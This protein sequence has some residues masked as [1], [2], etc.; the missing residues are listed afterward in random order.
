MAKRIRE[1]V[2]R[3][4]REHLEVMKGDFRDDDEIE[5]RILCGKS[6][7]EHAV[8]SFYHSDNVW[9]GLHQGKPVL[10]FGH[11]RDNFSTSI[12]CPWFASTNELLN[13][14]LST[15]RQSRHYVQE[16]KRNAHKLETLVH[17]KN[18]VSRKWLEWSGFNIDPPE[19]REDTGELFHKVWL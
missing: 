7:Y 19:L 2:I 15:V 1:L 4:K 6:A 14:G 5:S 12:S 18:V 16:M 13:V 3:A 9:V 17:A 8:Y 10:I 11:T